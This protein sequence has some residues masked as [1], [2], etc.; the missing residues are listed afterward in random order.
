MLTLEGAEGAVYGGFSGMLGQGRMERLQP[1]GDDVWLIPCLRALDHS[2]PGY[3]T[4]AFQRDET[5]TLTGVRVGCWLARDL[6]YRRCP[7]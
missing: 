5:G 4:L 1:L 7:D 6:F 3:W 2:P